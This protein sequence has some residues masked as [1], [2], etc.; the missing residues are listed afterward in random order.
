MF[1]KN[2]F[3]GKAVKESYH[4]RR[5]E[6]KKY[7][8]VI[9]DKFRPLLDDFRIEQLSKLGQNAKIGIGAGL[10]GV[11]VISIALFL[12][13]SNDVHKVIIAGQEVGYITE[14]EMV[15]KTLEEIKVDVY[16][17]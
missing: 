17:F 1:L 6:V 15:D 8:A 11:A 12:N 10:L 14:E 13:I 3:N 5:K 4:K 2:S 16:F 9:A 7:T